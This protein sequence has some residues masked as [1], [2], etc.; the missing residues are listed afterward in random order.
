MHDEGEESFEA[1]NRLRFDAPCLVLVMPEYKM[2][3]DQDIRRV[4]YS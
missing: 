1:L 4:S 2:F 3:T